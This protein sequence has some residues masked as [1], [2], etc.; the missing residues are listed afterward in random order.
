MDEKKFKKLIYACIVFA[1]L[2]LG[3]LLLS[4]IFLP[5][6]IL[7]KYF[8]FNFNHPER[9]N[10]LVYSQLRKLVLLGLLVLLFLLVAKYSRLESVKKLT[11]SFEKFVL[12]VLSIR[13]LL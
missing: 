9:V 4:H 6:D 1:V 11:H 2:M 7:S 10:I 3:F 12:K 8:S 13:F 5:S